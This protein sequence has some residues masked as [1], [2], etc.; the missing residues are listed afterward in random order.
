MRLFYS[1]PIPQSGLPPDTVGPHLFFTQDPGPNAVTLTRLELTNDDHLRQAGASILHAYSE[2]LG[3][4]K[5]DSGGDLR[6][7][8][9]LAAAVTGLSCQEFSNL[10]EN[11]Q[12]SHRNRFVRGPIHQELAPHLIV[13]LGSGPLHFHIMP[14]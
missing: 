5:G 13:Y 14:C 1:F 8:N 3:M 6:L 9:G 12:E 10:S 2:L 11:T 7:Q 4:L